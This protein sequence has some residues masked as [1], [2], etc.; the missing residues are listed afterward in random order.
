MTGPQLGTRGFLPLLG[1]A[2]ETDSEARHQA[3]DVS[4]KP[5]RRQNGIHL[6]PQ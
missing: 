1:S 3:A 6:W 4:L 5:R 2:G